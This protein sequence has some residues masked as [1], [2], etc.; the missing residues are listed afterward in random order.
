MRVRTARRDDLDAIVRLLADDEHGRARE[1]LRDPLPSAYAE[2]FARIEADLNT[3]ILV[4]EIDGAVVGC[5]QLTFIQGLSHRGAMKAEIGAVF[6]A[7]A[8]RNRGIGQALV[9]NALD[10]ARTRGCASR[11]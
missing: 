3:Q 10:L 8:H 9:E 11:N 7:S 2:A 6:V 4:A 5:L 1:D